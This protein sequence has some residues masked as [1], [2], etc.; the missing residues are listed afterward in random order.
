MGAAKHLGAVEM[1]KRSER[2]GL[3]VLLRPVLFLI[4]LRH[5]PFLD[6]RLLLTRLMQLA[7]IARGAKLTRSKPEPELAIFWF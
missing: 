5:M 4:I 3:H 7:R 2:A 6:T 1:G